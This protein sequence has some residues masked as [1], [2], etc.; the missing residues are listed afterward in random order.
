MVLLAQRTLAAGSGVARDLS[1]PHYASFL[2]ADA[3][4]E[5]FNR[6]FGESGRSTAGRATQTPTTPEHSVRLFRKADL[7]VRHVAGDRALS[8]HAGEE[9]DLGDDVPIRELFLRTANGANTDTDWAKKRPGAIS[10]IHEAVESAAEYK[11]MRGYIASGE[12]QQ[13]TSQKK[14]LSDLI[15]SE[16]ER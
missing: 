13:Y 8:N 14:L 1:G 3:V 15:A 4:G 10:R 11:A 2:I 9:A 16:R 5:K 12:L 6:A 7:T